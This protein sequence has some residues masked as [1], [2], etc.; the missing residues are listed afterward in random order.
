MRERYEVPQADGPVDWTVEV[1][2]SKSMTNRALLMAALSD[3][4]VEL[5]G[6]LFSDDS[7]YFL[8]SLQSLGFSVDISEADKKVTVRGEGGRIPRKEAE[9]YVGSAGTAA[10]FLTAMLGFSDG[11]YTVQASGQMK[12]R[13]MDALFELLEDAG[14]GITYLEKEGFLPVRIRGRGY[15]TA[16]QQRMEQQIEA[17]QLPICLE[18]DISRSTQF[19]SALLLAAPM[20]KQGLHIHITS[21]KT[22]GSYIRI[23]REMLKS[24]GVEA[25]FDG[26]D[27]EIAPGASYHKKNY[28]IEPDVSA[29]CYFYAAAAVTG[30]RALVRNVRR[31]NSQGDMKFLDVLE[32]MG[33]KV[34]E[35]ETGIEVQ[36]PADGKLGGIAVNMNDFSDQALT[37]AAIAPYAS[38]KVRIEGIGHIRLQECDRLHAIAAELSK[39]GILCAEEKS[40]VTV[41]PGRPRAGI[42]ETYDDHRVAMAFSLLG[43]RTAGIVID[44]PDCC[45]KTFE[46]YFDILDCLLTHQKIQNEGKK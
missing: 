22:D 2:G 16:E 42:V 40:A 12:K 41:Y 31:D 5:E 4:E 7:R 14:A 9:I 34:T 27:Y 38:D 11:I 20:M 39:R 23:T 43:L 37:L 25:A 21:K 18:L 46:E 3:G 13:P 33:C 30:G 17:Q 8:A 19:L 28:Q 10:R 44:H 26:R 36:G 32:R 6:V 1:P 45:K 35:R 24:A 29:A 15:R